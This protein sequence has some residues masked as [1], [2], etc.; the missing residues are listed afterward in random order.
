M[1]TN[2]QSR[3]NIIQ[4]NSKGYLYQRSIDHLQVLLYKAKS[5]NK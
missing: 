4:I 2:L 5:P 3:G 1:N